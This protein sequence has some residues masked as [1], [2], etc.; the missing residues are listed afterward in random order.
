[1]ERKIYFSQGD[2]KIET[3]IDEIRAL[4]AAQ[5]A[6]ERQRQARMDREGLK[7]AL[8]AVI[9]FAGCLVILAIV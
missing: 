7:A 1:M 2:R 3:T 5:G 6:A 8:W 4:R 9:G